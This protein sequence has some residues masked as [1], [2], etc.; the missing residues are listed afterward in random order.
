MEIDSWLVSADT[1]TPNRA[2]DIRV[3]KPSNGSSPATIWLK[4]HEKSQARTTHLSPVNSQHWK[5][6]TNC[7]FKLLNLWWFVTQQWITETL[8]IVLA[9]VNCYNYSGTHKLERFPALLY[10]D[11]LLKERYSEGPSWLEK[12]RVSFGFDSRT[13]HQSFSTITDIVIRGRDNYKLL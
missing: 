1:A 6:T 7:Y 13:T 9:H 4:Q 5:R 3:R 2:P 11:I 10:G 8:S 12:N